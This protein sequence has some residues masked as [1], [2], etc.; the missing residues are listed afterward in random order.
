MD[1]GLGEGGAGSLFKIRCVFGEAS[2]DMKGHSALK[3]RE[4]VL[5]P[6]LQTPSPTANVSAQCLQWILKAKSQWPFVSPEQSAINSAA[7]GAGSCEKGVV[8]NVH[9]GSGQA[10]RIVARR[11]ART[12]PRLCLAPASRRGSQPSQCGC[13]CLCRPRPGAGGNRTSGPGA[14]LPPPGPEEPQG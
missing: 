2:W 10:R 13:C 12:E 11:E 6:S 8:M 5:L 9:D 3:R 7:D 4:T 1:G 14:H